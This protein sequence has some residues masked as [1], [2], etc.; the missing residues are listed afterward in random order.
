LRSGLESKYQEAGPK[1]PLWEEISTG[2]QRMGYK[3]SAKRCK[4]KWEN[5]NKYFKKVKESNKNRSEDAKTCPYFHELDA[6]YR[7]KILGGSGGGGGGGSTS[8][9]GFDSQSRPQEQ[10]QQE[11]LQLD[12]MPHPM[13]QPPQQTQTTESQNKNGAGGDVQAS[14]IGLPGNLGEGNGGAAK[15]VNLSFV[16]KRKKNCNVT[17]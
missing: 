13:Q 1:G 14:N 16:Q 5:I 10:Q 2:M 8:T 11:S 4:E 9:S 7:K 12:P 3:R 6:L 17:K 15:K